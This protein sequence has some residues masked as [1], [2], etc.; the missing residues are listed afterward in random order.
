MA[1]YI[2]RNDGTFAGSLGS[3][4]S[5]VPTSMHDV[6]R[7]QEPTHSRATDSLDQLHQLYERFQSQHGRAPVI[8]LD[9]DGTSANLVASLRDRV[10]STRRIPADRAHHELPDPDHYSMWEAT[11]PWFSDLEDFLTHFEEGERTGIYRELPAYEGLH[12]AVRQIRR[13]GFEIDVVTAR[14]SRFNHDTRAWL[15]SHDLPVGDIHNPGIDKHL[16]S[17]I[18]VFIDDSP[19]VIET[20]QAHGRKVIIFQQ[21][22][23][24]QVHQQD[25]H[26]R[27]IPGWHLPSLSS[28]LSK[29]LDSLSR[30]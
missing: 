22:Y 16:V 9:L 21:P 25:E 24:T 6:T 20:L 18:D 28:A 29:L 14:P 27:R 15:D 13:V 2:R 10:A 4:K 12:D 11:S 5:N 17:H 30:D 23:N 3:G 19:H 1:K 8:G 26:A 7:Q